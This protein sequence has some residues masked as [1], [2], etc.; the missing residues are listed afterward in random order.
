MAIELIDGTKLPA[1]PTEYDNEGDETAPVLSDLKYRAVFYEP[2]YEVYHLFFCSK[3][4]AYLSVEKDFFPTDALVADSSIVQVSFVQFTFWGAPG[5]DCSNEDEWGT[6]ELDGWGDIRLP[7]MLPEDEYEPQW[8]DHNIRV[9]AKVPELDDN[10]T[11]EI[12]WTNDIYFPNCVKPI[13][14]SDGTQ[15][16]TIPRRALDAGP[17]MAVIRFKGSDN[18]SAY[19]LLVSPKPAFISKVGLRPNTSKE[20]L[21]LAPER[22]F[23]AYFDNEMTE[24][25][26]MLD[27]TNSLMPVYDLSEQQSLVWA[28]H[29]ICCMAEY[30]SDED[31]TIGTEIARKSDVNYRIT[32]GVM[33]DFAD[34]AR[35]LGASSASLT[36]AEIET[37][38]RAV[39]AASGDTGTVEIVSWADGTDEQ[40]AAMVAAMDAGTLSIEDTGWAV[41][42]ERQVTLSAMEATGV[43]ESHVEQT[44]TLVLMDSQHYTLTEATA[45]GDTMDHF[46]VG[47]KGVLANGNSSESGYMNSAHTNSGS[48]SGCARRTWCNEVFRIAIPETLRGCFKQFK[49]P[50]ATE[51]NANT[52]TETDD[53]FALFAEKEVFGSC[54]YSNTTEAAA[55]TQ[56]KWYETKDNRKKHAGDTEYIYHWWERSPSQSGNSQFCYATSAAGVNYMGAGSS[57]SISP[58]GCI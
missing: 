10:V 29:D 37:I 7:G 35:R 4:F 56:I 33:R 43:G 42:D 26:V 58:F 50:T 44:V 48:W 46:V 11:G 1:F 19:Y 55:L 25:Q 34:Q 22:R 31:Y 52:V 5:E 45:G 13:I 9:I 24:W 51:Y 15:L 21:C 3:P 49:V 6:W 2:G 23:V 38:F 14:L 28:N 40:I 41:G 32:E 16:P 57:I 39:T 20:Q 53:Y 54:T 36:P 18:F 47:M 12:I 8:A 30:N 27:G 17:Y